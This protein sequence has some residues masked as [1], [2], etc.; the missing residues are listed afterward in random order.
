MDNV[1]LPPHLIREDIGSLQAVPHDVNTCS[2]QEAS[3]LPQISKLD[4]TFCPVY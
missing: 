4:N 2:V 3:S 1:G